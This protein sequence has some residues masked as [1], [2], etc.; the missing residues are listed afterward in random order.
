M[1]YRVVIRDSVS[2]GI[3]LAT[4]LAYELGRDADA[5]SRA[6]ADVVLALSDNPAEQGESRAGSERVIIAH[7]FTA[8]YE[9]FEA[10][11]VVIVYSAV[12]YPRQRL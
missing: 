2:K 4:F 7:P 10:T 9:V 6:V 11:Q 12:Y 1:T 5:L 8:V 3:H